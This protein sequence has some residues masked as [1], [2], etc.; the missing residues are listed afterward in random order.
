VNI[1]FVKIEPGE[2]EFFGRHLAEHALHSVQRLEEVG[3]DAEI[4]SVFTDDPVDAA[5][6]ASRPALRCVATR[7]TSMDH[8]DL[9]ACAQRGVEVCFV[10]HYAEETI[11]EHVF[12]LI[13][14]LARRLREL[15]RLPKGGT[16]SYEATRGFELQGKTLGVIGMGRI[17]QRVATLA[18]AFQMRVVGYDIHS[19]P[20]LARTLRF[21]WM[22]LD[23][24][25]SQSDILSLHAPLSPA[26]YHI[27]NAESLSRTKRGVLIINTARG[28]LIDTAALR[29]ALESG[30]I[31]G[32]GLDVLQD[33]RVLRRRAESVIADD[34]LRQLRT[35]GVARE[36]R[37]ADRVRELEELMLGD[38]VLAR[39]N[40]VFT[41][42]VAFNTHEAIHRLNETTLANIR[43][44][45]EG[46]PQNRAVT[47]PPSSG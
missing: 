21:Q 5:F 27:L 39:P 37:D 2:E 43:A 13:L 31:G 40:V 3:T 28:A 47:K 7:S 41:P 44:F 36:A 16:F 17:G 19:L 25:L 38:A 32:A 11:A 34:I 33:E 14:A 35:D 30:H 45:I 46:R 23:D 12:A 22:S 42:H 20:D 4:V 8:I 9:E 10:P 24:L 29:N 15:M 1:Y 18:H 6:F 26:T